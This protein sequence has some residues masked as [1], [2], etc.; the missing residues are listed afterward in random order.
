MY[1]IRQDL[2]YPRNI[3]QKITTLSSTKQDDT[4][5]IN[6]REYILQIK[7]TTLREGTQFITL[8]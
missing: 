2:Y 8:R 5:E 7:R 4:T 6:G 1:E 3:I